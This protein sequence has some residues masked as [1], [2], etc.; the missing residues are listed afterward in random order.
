MLRVSELLNSSRTK[1]SKSVGESS[2]AISFGTLKHSLLEATLWTPSCKMETNVC[3]NILPFQF[4][5]MRV[6]LWQ[7]IWEAI[8]VLLGTP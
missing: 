5:H 7:S 6:E 1:E 8:E 2:S 4:I 3:P